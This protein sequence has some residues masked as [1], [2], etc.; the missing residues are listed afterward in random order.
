MAGDPEALCHHPERLGGEAPGD[1]NVDVFTVNRSLRPVLVLVHP[2]GCGRH[3]A[4]R[5]AH[6]AK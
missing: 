1:H 2:S 3:P 5:V 6:V 4:D